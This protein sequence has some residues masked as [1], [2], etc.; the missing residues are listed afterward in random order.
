MQLSATY[1]EKWFNLLIILYYDTDLD[2]WFL[3]IIH[4]IQF[5]IVVSEFTMHV[6]YASSSLASKV[7]KTIFPIT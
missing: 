5:Y 3:R 2:I 7:E 6:L 4:F 1:T